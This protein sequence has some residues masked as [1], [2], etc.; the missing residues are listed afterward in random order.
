MFTW[1]FKR[2]RGVENIPTREMCWTWK[3]EHRVNWRKSRGL[4][5]VLLASQ[6]SQARP[7]PTQR[8]HLAHI[9]F[10]SVCLQLNIDLLAQDSE[11]SM[12]T[13]SRLS[14]LALSSESE[15]ITTRP[16]RFF[17]FTI[18][19]YTA[20]LLATAVSSKC[21]WLAVCCYLASSRCSL[22][23][24][25]QYWACALLIHSW[26]RKPPRISVHAKQIFLS[27]PIYVRLY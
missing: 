11:T 24:Q 1:C 26:R 15:S 14:S 23:T 6:L 21:L 27:D 22:T 18:F 8:I 7:P 4:E 10:T 19:S 9:S 25:R 16:F 2:P 20:S 17:T 5:T 13:W 3:V 12:P